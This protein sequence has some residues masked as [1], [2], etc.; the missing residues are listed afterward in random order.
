MELLVLLGT[1]LLVNASIRLFIKATGAN[2]PRLGVKDYLDIL[3]HGVW[4]DVEMV[5]T[6][7]KERHNFMVPA[8]EILF[9]LRYLEEQK[10]AEHR[11]WSKENDPEAEIDQ[12]RKKWKIDDDDKR[13]RQKGRRDWKRWFIP[14]PIP[15]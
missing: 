1:A 3:E 2:R 14:Q 6:E 15:A 7:I 12:F 10:L 11:V 8:N 9:F 5:S 4:K 13:P